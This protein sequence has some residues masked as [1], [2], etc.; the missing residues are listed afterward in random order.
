MR[1]PGAI[2][3]SGNTWS[4]VTGYFQVEG[5]RPPP[6]VRHLQW[7]EMPLCRCHRERSGEDRSCSRFWR[8]WLCCHQSPPWVDKRSFWHNNDWWTCHAPKHLPLSPLDESCG[9]QWPVAKGTRMN[10][11]DEGMDHLGRTRHHILLESGIEHGDRS[12]RPLD[13]IRLVAPRENWWNCSG[14]KPEVWENHLKIRKDPIR[15]IYLVQKWCMWSKIG[16]CVILRATGKPNQRISE[17]SKKLSSCLAGLRS[18]SSFATALASM[19]MVDSLSIN[20]LSKISTN[21]GGALEWDCSPETESRTVVQPFSTT[22]AT[23][24]N[25]GVKLSWCLCI[26]LFNNKD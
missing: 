24:D 16:K 18:S 8:S 21:L 20:F 12:G 17:C 7:L 6:E 19:P 3:P 26:S 23:K 10:R 25:S 1:V 2:W 22:P 13:C 9:W 5:S 11:D 14:E 15:T 4:F